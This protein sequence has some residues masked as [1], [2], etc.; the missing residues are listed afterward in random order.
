MFDNVTCSGHGVKVKGHWVKVKCHIGQGQ[1]RSATNNSLLFG[2]YA[3]YLGVKNSLM[4]N[5][6]QGSR[7]WGE[8]SSIVS[9]S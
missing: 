4:N 6:L 3:P 5:R 9:T 8:V 7:M 2:Y 1:I